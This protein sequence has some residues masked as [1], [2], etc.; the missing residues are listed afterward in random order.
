MVL[1][2]LTLED[3]TVRVHGNLP[4]ARGATALHHGSHGAAR[5]GKVLSSALLTR[6]PQSRDPSSTGIVFMWLHTLHK[7]FLGILPREHRRRWSRI[8]VGVICKQGILLPIV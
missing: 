4:Y 5:L 6:N 3:R 2:M 8:S 1:L 7:G